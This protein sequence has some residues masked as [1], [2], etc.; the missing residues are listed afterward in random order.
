MGGKKEFLLVNQHDMTAW[1][2]CGAKLL[3]WGQNRW[4]FMSMDP[5]GSL[6]GVHGTQ[7]YKV[8]TYNQLCLGDFHS[9]Q[10]PLLLFSPPELS[11]GQHAV[12]M[13]PPAVLVPREGTVLMGQ[14]TAKCTPDTSLLPLTQVEAEY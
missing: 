5:A 4:T 2:G 3:C 13:S 10:D 1:L 7:P 6:W 14:D 9:V 11:Q 12:P 8:G